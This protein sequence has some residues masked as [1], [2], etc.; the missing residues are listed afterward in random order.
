M[1]A[2]TVRTDGKKD[3]AAPPA[4]VGPV[5]AGNITATPPASPVPAAAAAPA[6][7]GADPDVEHCQVSA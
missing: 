7:D 3:D 4:A 6:T 1:D 2:A 5:D